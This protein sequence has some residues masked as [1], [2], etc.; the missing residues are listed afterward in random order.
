[1]G[2]GK[3]IIETTTMGIKTRELMMAGQSWFP[4]LTS[5]FRDPG[6]TEIITGETIIEGRHGQSVT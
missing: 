6:L 1:M 4:M 2:L 5:G 3:T